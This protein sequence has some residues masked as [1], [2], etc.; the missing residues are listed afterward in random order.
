VKS[1]A[2]VKAPADIKL[3]STPWV[4]ANAANI[5]TY[6]WY[7]SGDKQNTVFRLMYDDDALYAQFICEDKH[8]DAKPRELNGAV[9]QDSCVEL[10]VTPNPFC[11]EKYFNF[12]ANCCGAFHVG[13]A[14][15]RPDRKLISSELAEKITVVTPYE[16]PEKSI[17]KDDNGW[18]LAAK[19]P[20][21]ALESY[22]DCPLTPQSGDTWKA[23]LYRCG[24]SIDDQYAVW[25][26][27][28]WEHPDFHRPEFFGELKFE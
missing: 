11:N 13:F 5:E 4:G 7:Q 19:I 6:P 25:N 20:F 24:G 16:T 10:F 26:D 15:G 21:A 23:N 14:P 17:C 18:W 27:I 22:F 1:Y 12:E 9:C 28:T 3:D 2:I 8:I